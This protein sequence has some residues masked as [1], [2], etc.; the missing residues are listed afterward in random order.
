MAPRL[1][2][3]EDEDT[4]EAVKGILEGEGITVRCAAKCVAL[5]KADRG[6]TVR[7]E[8][9]PGADSATG[10]HVHWRLAGSRTPTISGSTA[11]ASRSTRV[12][13]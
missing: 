3:R 13:T 10:S 12:G 5:G 9:E 11:R 1:I 6:V 2:G 4:S 7:L 8:C